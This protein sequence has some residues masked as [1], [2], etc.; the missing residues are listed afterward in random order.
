MDEISF[1]RE[2]RKE[3]LTNLNGLPSFVSFLLIFDEGKS[4]MNW[5]VF[6]LAPLHLDAARRKGELRKEPK[7][8][9]C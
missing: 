1:R 2:N 3:E 6:L 8:K 9:D 4:S 7:R 5:M